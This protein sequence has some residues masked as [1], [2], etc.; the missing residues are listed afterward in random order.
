MRF[1][2]NRCWPGLRAAGI[3]SSFLMAGSALAFAQTPQDRVQAPQDRVMEAINANASV[4]LAGSANPRLASQVPTGRLSPA[5]PLDGVT[6][7]FKPTAEQKAELDALVEAQQTPGS[8]EYHQWLTPAEYGS[9]FG[10]SSSDLAKV[11]SW[12]TSEGFNVERVGNSH[13]S[14]TFSG[15]AAQVENAFRTEMQQY[16]VDGEKHFSNATDLSIP[17][18]AGWGGA[19][20]AEPG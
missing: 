6:I 3:L 9:L 13:T 1:W 14:I 15:T 7:Y 2:N 19:V 4:A 10:L 20:G 8:P 12:L 16:V 18:C 11:A 17:D 5:T